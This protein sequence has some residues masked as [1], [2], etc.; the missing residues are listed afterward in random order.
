MERGKSET[1]LTRDRMRC[2]Q[3]GTTGS[4]RGRARV[5]SADDAWAIG[6]SSAGKMGRAGRSDWVVREKRSGVMSDGGG[7]AGGK[8]KG[9]RCL[10][11]RICKC[12]SGSFGTCS[13]RLPHNPSLATLTNEPPE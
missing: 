5:A 8:G 7:R 4:P 6:V 2:A 9:A 11:S 3:R 1:R 13:V 12:G 10:E